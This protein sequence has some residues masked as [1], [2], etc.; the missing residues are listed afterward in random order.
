MTTITSSS[1]PSRARYS[2]GP[3]SWLRPGA[4]RLATWITVRER[5]VPSMK[6]SPWAKLIISMMP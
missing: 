2:S 6:T 3:G 4:R 1:T 5:K